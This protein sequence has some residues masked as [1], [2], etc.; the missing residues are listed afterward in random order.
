M[1]AA[2]LIACVPDFAQSPDGPLG[3]TVDGLVA[4][5]RQLSPALRAAALDT[6]AAAATAIGADALDDPTISDRC[7]RACARMPARR[8]TRLPISPMCG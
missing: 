1:L 5:G 6:A 8:S 2:S 4:A 7:G 3:A